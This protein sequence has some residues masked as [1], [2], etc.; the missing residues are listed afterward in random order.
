M[1]PQYKDL[2]SSP[3]MFQKRRNRFEI[4]FACVV[5]VVG[6]ML[7]IS[8]YKLVWELAP[9]GL[10]RL[11]KG[12][13]YWDFTNLWSGSRLALDGRVMAL[14]N[15]DEYR[16][17]L[18]LM[19]NPD[20]PD[21]EWSYPPS[22]LL[23]GMPLAL[24]PISWSYWVWTI[25][26][27]LCLHFAI[28]PAKLPLVFH[29]AVLTSPSVC[30]SA[31]LGQNGALTAALLIG[32]LFLTQSRPVLAGIL[33]GMLV[34]KPHL[35]LLIPVCLIVSWN[36]RSFISATITVLVIA[37]FTGFLLGFD[38][39]GAFFTKTSDLM[40]SIM[41]SPFPHPYFR[42]A[43]TAFIFGRSLG[44]TVQTSY[45]LQAISTLISLGLTAYLWWPSNRFDFLA[46]VSITVVLTNMATPYGY[47]YDTVPFLFAV[48]VWFL[49]TRSLNVLFF[50][51]M[52]LVP[53]LIHLVN[54]QTYSIG[55]F[56]N[57]AFALYCLREVI[58]TRPQTVALS[59][60][61]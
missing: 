40:V 31:M 25:G 17:V 42:Q 61:E 55:V 39:W 54:M 7:C 34:I 15:V 48:A 30:F 57:L 14:F 16:A 26:T 9:N 50:G 1:D 11:S 13:P 28:K 2:P 47:S 18:R 38:V 19:H 24:F 23:I 43:N 5:Y 56:L 6:L 35:G 33:L 45:A 41:E 49:R 53:G 37:A 3:M 58:Q 59:K 36:I 27:I 12:L 8:M 4:G 44:L 10:S 52:W 29:V 60:Q 51:V 46:K 32:G 20:L 22:I 21:M